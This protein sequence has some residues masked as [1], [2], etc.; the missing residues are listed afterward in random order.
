MRDVAG[1]AGVSTATVSI[2][3]NSS[4]D[5]ERRVTSLTRQRVVAAALELG[6][7]ANQAAR[8]LRRGRTEQ[9]TLALRWPDSPWTQGMAVA[10]GEVAE[11]NG[12]SAV[13]L[14]SGD[15]QGYLSKGLADGA[16]IDAVADQAF[17]LTTIQP[18]L[19]R[20]M[21]IVLLNNF[22]EPDGFDVVR[23]NEL[24]VCKQAVNALIDAGH[25][26]IAC[27]RNDVD[28]PPN[29][30]GERY[31][32]YQETLAE[33]G[34]PIR[35]SLIRHVGG[36]R[37]LAFQASLE[38]L[39]RGRNRPTAIYA[40]S[41]LAAISALW[42]ARRLGLDVPGD[43]EILGTGNSPEGVYTDPPLSSIGP[44][45]PDFAA[46]GELVFSRL[47]AAK[48]LPARV[49]RQEWCLVPRGTALA[50]WTPEG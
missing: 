4:G 22:V 43:V 5:T 19:A 24:A 10:I 31:A 13:L 50:S 42:A 2:V 34:V 16:V 41:D 20:G 26:R 28:D 11:Q 9:I 35:P 23:S 18:L 48:P 37:E 45:Q 15:W 36:S 8:G 33:R 49:H 40:A 32:A 12:Y 17:D 7:V 14:A 30:V 46:V 38:L 3:L 6:Y 44:R 1:R 25:R 29:L 21:A 27:L 39:Q 47:N